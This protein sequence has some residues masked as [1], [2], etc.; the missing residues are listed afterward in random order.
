MCCCSSASRVSFGEQLG[1]GQ[2]CGAH[3]LGK[4]SYSVSVAGILT[5]IIIVIITI[6]LVSGNSSTHC[7]KYYYTTASVS[8]ILLRQ[9][10]IVQ[11]L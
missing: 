11:F 7:A 3:Q 1:R 5:T 10:S 2:S 8:T 4:A 9:L 6:S